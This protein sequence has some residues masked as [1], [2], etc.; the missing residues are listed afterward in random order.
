MPSTLGH[1]AVSASFDP[2]ARIDGKLRYIDE[3]ERL[4]AADPA[5]LYQAFT[6]GIPA[7]AP[8][9][10]AEICQA[11]R[12]LGFPELRGVVQGVDLCDPSQADA[13]LEILIRS[14]KMAAENGVSKVFAV[15]QQWPAGSMHADFFHDLL[16][17]FV[18][19]VSAALRE[20]PE[21]DEFGIEPLIS[22]EQQH[23]NSLAKARLMARSV[24]QE[25]GQHRVYPVPDL[26]HLFGLVDRA[27][28]P[29]VTD[30]LIDAITAGEVPYAHLSIPE[31]RTD[32]ILPAIEAG[33][34][35]QRALHALYQVAAVDTEGFDPND[36]F[37]DALRDLVPKFQSAD[38]SGW[39]DDQRF[40]RFVA[41]AEFLHSGGA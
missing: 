25:L 1:I 36:P 24:N 14:L 32:Q 11:L 22:A 21:T 20:V 27:F 29:D 13:S 7:D 10:Y 38:A 2:T 37:L 40:D 9:D 12:G 16:P 30:Q 8:A 3:A 34:V 6:F 15:A 5:G 26:A 18:A 17:S 19:T 41:A 39:T 23:V 4:R 35:P 31:S 28:W 33:D